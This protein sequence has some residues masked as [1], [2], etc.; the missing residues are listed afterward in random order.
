MVAI[1]LCLF[2]TWVTAQDYLARPVPLIVPIV[3]GC[4]T[5]ILAPHMAQS[6]SARTP[7]AAVVDG[8]AQGLDGGNRVGREAPGAGGRAEALRGPVGGGDAATRGG[9]DAERERR[10]FRGRELVRALR[11]GCD[12]GADRFPAA[13]CR[14]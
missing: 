2:A 8:R 12:A 13:R 10:R 11:A 9:A 1:I 3:P 7:A 6:V 4:G 14:R 5:D